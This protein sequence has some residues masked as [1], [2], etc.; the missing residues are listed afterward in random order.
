LQLE[1]QNITEFLRRKRKRT[2]ERDIERSDKN[3]ILLLGGER[4]RERER[5]GE[6][7]GEGERERGRERALWMAIQSKINKGHH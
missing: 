3:S 7:E 5:E 6:G 1:K 2:Q 4:E